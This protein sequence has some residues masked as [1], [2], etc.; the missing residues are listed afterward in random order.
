[1]CIES[2]CLSKSLASEAVLSPS[3][4]VKLNGCFLWVSQTLQL[5]AST[6]VSVVSSLSSSLSS[7]KLQ[8]CFQW[9]EKVII[10]ACCC[11]GGS[12]SGNSSGIN[13]YQLPILMFMQD[14]I[15]LLNDYITSSN[16]TFESVT[17]VLTVICKWTDM[18]IPFAAQF[19]HL[20]QF[21]KVIQRLCVCLPPD[22]PP[23]VLTR[24][25]RFLGKICNDD[26]D[27]MQVVA[28]VSHVFAKNR[29]HGST[30][31]AGFMLDSICKKENINI[32]DKLEKDCKLCISEIVKSRGGGGGDSGGNTTTLKHIV[33]SWQSD[34]AGLQNEM[35][36]WKK[37]SSSTTTA[38][39]TTVGGHGGGGKVCDAF[40]R[41]VNEATFSL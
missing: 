6:D 14:T 26:K 29:Q 16:P 18:L 7:V 12:S 40:M 33:L 37:T 30:M 41:S 4:L 35:N 10:P 38:T 31:L 32:A 15:G 21:E 28:T 25:T 2:D 13:T 3:F 20:D 27:D 23:E 1:M 11:I 39:T 8:E 34:N 17:F 36:V 24:L 5:A 22:T 19:N 9:M